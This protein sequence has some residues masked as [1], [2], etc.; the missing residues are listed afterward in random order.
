M[1]RGIAFSF[2][3]ILLSV[4]QLTV[5]QNTAPNPAARWLSHIHYLA[6]DELAGRETGSEGHRRA[7][8]LSPTRSDEPD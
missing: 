8:A 2:L 5:A 6:S 3:T 4:S 7:A 1:L